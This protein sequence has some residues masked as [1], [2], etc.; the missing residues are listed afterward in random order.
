MI[1]HIKMD[2]FFEADDIDD[3]IAWLGCFFFTR[4]NSRGDSFTLK[5]PSTLDIFADS[6]EPEYWETHNLGGPKDA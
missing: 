4:N 1:F 3:A 6:N 5:S 2:A